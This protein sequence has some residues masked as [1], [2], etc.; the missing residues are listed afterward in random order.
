MQM[1]YPAWGALRPPSRHKE[2][3]Q[4]LGLELPMDDVTAPLVDNDSDSSCEFEMGI[5]NAEVHKGKKIDDSDS[6]DR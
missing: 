5:Q 3:T 6:F 1:Q 4:N 2:P